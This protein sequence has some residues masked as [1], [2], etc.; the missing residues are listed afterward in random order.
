VT[1]QEG[2]IK[3]RLDYQPCAPRYYPEYAELNAWR[4]ILYR[5][6]LI[7]QDP[8]RYGGLAYGNISF[9]LGNTPQ[10][11]I[12][13]SQTSGLTRLSNDNYSTVL[14]AE[15]SQNHIVATGAIK[16]S[17]EALTHAAVYDASHDVKAVVHVH[18]PIIWQHYQAL[19]LPTIDATIQYG[20]QAMAEAVLALF[21]RNV[22][23]EKPIFVMLGH[24]DGIVAIG[25]SIADAS[26]VLIRTLALAMEID[27]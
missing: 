1:E 10:F 9:R 16:P 21:A 5:L 18:S 17:S 19:A 15:P 25:D 2:V 12:T 23:T 13:G 26:M 24:E 11:I 6:G 27:S 7:G 4:S 14:S 20:T 8:L 3:Y 22:L